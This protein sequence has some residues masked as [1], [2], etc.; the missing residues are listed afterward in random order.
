MMQATRF[1]D[2]AKRSVTVQRLA[3]TLACARSISTMRNKAAYSAYGDGHRM[4]I[5]IQ[6]ILFVVDVCADACHARYVVC[7]Y[8]SRQ[9]YC[10]EN[11]G[12][13]W[14]PQFKS[15][16]RQQWALISWLC[17]GWNIMPRLHA[18]IGAALVTLL[19]K[20]FAMCSHNQ[21]RYERSWLSNASS[22]LTAWSLVGC[23]Q[24]EPGPPWLQLMTMSACNSLRETVGWPFI[25]SH[26]GS[27]AVLYL[28]A[29]KLMKL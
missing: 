10:Y 2:C 21:R 22:P 3:G 14:H 1:L 28:Q 19:A 7:L 4:S 12:S 26:H 6:G 13:V 5:C 25:L 16:A 23:S 18:C 15:C 27:D 9:G 29:G 24:G 20:R 8:L 17:S 11:R